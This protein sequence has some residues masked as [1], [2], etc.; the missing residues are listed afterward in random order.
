MAS[1]PCLPAACPPATYLVVVIL[2]GRFDRVDCERYTSD[3]NIL[4]ANRN[5]IE[6]EASG[7]IEYKVHG[8]FSSR[9]GERSFPDTF[10]FSARELK[11]AGVPKRTINRALLA[12]HAELRDKG[13]GELEEV[14]S[15]EDEDR[16]LDEGRG[17]AD[18]AEEGSGALESGIAADLPATAGVNAV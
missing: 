16:S 7:V 1:H 3:E 5:S 9:E 12:Y 11:D 2:R 15:D 6:D 13:M 17:E 14:S 8:S 18:G 10:M 4:G